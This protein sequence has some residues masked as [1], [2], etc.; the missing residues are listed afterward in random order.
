MS[1][2]KTVNKIIETPPAEIKI[3]FAPG[4]FD[5][6]DGSQEEL[7][8]L[9]SKIQSMISNGSLFDNSTSI[10]IDALAESDDPEDQLLLEKLSRSFE[11]ETPRSLQ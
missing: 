5:N 10:D 9:V 1:K 8:D 2:K 7:D 4:A 6:F 3:V 11:D